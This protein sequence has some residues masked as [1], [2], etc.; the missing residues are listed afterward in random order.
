M[1]KTQL[2]LA[3]LTGSI[4]AGA[5]KINQTVS[6]VPQGDIAAADLSTIISHLAGGIKRLGGNID[7]FSNVG[8]A[9]IKFGNS[10]TTA[11]KLHDG[12][13]DFLV[14]DSTND[15]I[16]IPRDDIKL[17]LGAAGDLKLFHD[18]TDS[19]ILNSTGQLRV[20]ADDLRLLN[21]A[22]GE[23]YATA[24]NNGA[25]T[26]YHDN[27][28][29]LATDAAG[30]TITGTAKATGGLI[31][32]AGSDEFSIT[33]S[34]DHI[35]IKTL[36][37]DKNMIFQLNDG[38]ADTEVFQLF[39]ADAALRMASGKHIQL[40]DVAESIHG[41]G[42]DIHFGV[43]AGG[44]INI[45]A[46]IGL[47]FGNDGEK[48]EGDGTDLTISG[49]IINLAADADV[50][51]PNNKGL[52]FGD[53]G[54]KIEGDGTDLTI[55]SSN[56]LNMTVGKKILIDAQGGASGD[57][58]EIFL[59]SDDANTK[60]QIKNN[61][62]AVKF[63]VDAFGDVTMGRDLIVTGD[64]TVNG[65]TTTLD[66]QNLN[67]EDPFV[68]LG[69]G[70]QAANSNTGIIFASG[71]NQGSRPDVAFGKMHN[72]NDTWVLGSVASHSGSISNLSTLVPD[73][74]FRVKKVELGDAAES[75]SADGTDINFAVGANGDIN[76]PANIGLTFGDDGEKIEGDGTDLTISGNNINLTAAVDV[77]IP[78]G[79]GLTFATAEKIESD[80]TDLSITV[81]AGGDINIGTDIGLTFGNDGEKIEGDGSKLVISAAN[82]DLTLEAGGDVKLPNDIGMI[83]GDAGEK[84]EG[85]GT[86]LTIAS[87]RRLQMNL[88]ED[89][90]VDAASKIRFDSDDFQFRL[91]DG[92][93]ERIRIHMDG[94][95][96]PVIESREQDKDIAFVVND[97]GA[98]VEPFRIIAATPG[99]QMPSNAYIQ[100]NDANE[101]ISGDGSK[102][103]LTSGGVTTHMPTTGGSA[104]QILEVDGAGQLSFVAKSA[105]APTRRMAV[106]TGSG[107]PAGEILL[108]NAAACSDVYGGNSAALAHDQGAK[109][110]K[111][112]IF[113][114][115]QLMSS[116]TSAADGDYAIHGLGAADK[117]KFF[118]ALEAD[119][120]ISTL[121]FS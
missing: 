21:A 22:G 40:G 74:G 11:Y 36:V 9:A 44:D 19:K 84:I 78:S 42:T 62:A 115:G 110:D 50:V 89:F 41:D 54:E 49:N 87:S 104:G 68:L 20:Q 109:A 31:V 81:G 79:V 113:V 17:A 28:A 71:S 37:T 10:A 53:A 105:T 93:T 29:K 15:E 92:G 86:D 27:V 100:W 75:I 23:T 114:N 65:T 121:I 77:N 98:I 30:A 57:G 69:D 64:L 72:V 55:A 8:A 48:I 58:V 61:S 60:F 120:I 5:G 59:G 12:A 111:S 13:K 76:I 101:K 103:S 102:L 34:S 108:L 116:G 39:A 51:L 38:G 45:P 112:Q 94:S 16:E 67:V 43:G 1:A 66:V 26:L 80:G 83:F 46:N 117:I 63:A 52:V 56:L 85:D 95:S 7:D 25:V 88:G 118:F 35:T 47:T 24:A 99:A 91:E 6:A 32:G 33:E 119:D 106:I 96:H 18:G 90:R 3:Q 107:A 82:L 4:G 97:G 73:I 70:A 2:R 14:F